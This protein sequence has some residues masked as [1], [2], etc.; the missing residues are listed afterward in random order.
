MAH[1]RLGRRAVLGTAL[2]MPALN[3]RAQ[4]SAV[5]LISHR[6]PALEWYADKMKSAVPGTTVDT[7]LMPS[8]DAAQM[9]RLQFSSASPGM[10]ILWLNSSLMAFYAKN[11]W[12]E[13]MDDLIATFRDEFKL[14]DLNPTSLRGMTYEGKVYGLPLTTN[15]LL[16]AYRED[17][18]S[19]RKL[20]PPRTWEE[21][22]EI[23]KALHSP[24]RSGTTL[25]LKWDM[26]PY[27]LSSVLHTVGDG[28]F[29]RDWR[30]V[31]N[32]AKGVA[33]I[34][35]YRRLS[36]FAVPGFS[37]QAN[38]E[39]TVNFAQDVA[40]TG[41][42]WATRCATMD[43]PQRSKVVGKIQW[44]VPPGGK[45]AIT[46]DGYAISRFSTKNKEMLFRILARALDED[47]QRG[48]ADLATPTRRAVLNDPAIQARFR[49]YPAVSK[50]LDVGEPLPALA[51]FNEAA[52]LACRRI[53]QAI[54]GQ[55]PVKA[56]LD[57]GAAEVVEL[58]T[59]RGYYKG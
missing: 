33:A 13:P 21:Q 1:H 56:A 4:G 12:L 48:A 17:V 50:C 14:G 55:M 59:R 57:A 54:V 15:T 25:S 22:V 23:A 28:W 2:A 49:W 18:F 27:E 58:L 46:T 31:F 3:V 40:A 53:V 35:L 51:E 44:A 24:R 39:N 26:P 7:R 8:G 9:Q 10:D 36:A 43:N 30:P 5:T 20:A 34:D 52:E 38:D 6:Y 29:D 11:G 41:Q 42:Q 16:Y 37:S 32:S 45:Q 47:S 19:E